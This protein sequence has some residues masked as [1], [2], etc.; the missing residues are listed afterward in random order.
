MEEGQEYT[1]KQLAAITGLKGQRVGGA[2]RHVDGKYVLKTGRKTSNGALKYKLIKKIPGS[3][4][5]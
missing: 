1:A 4:R 5:E 2:L 3:V